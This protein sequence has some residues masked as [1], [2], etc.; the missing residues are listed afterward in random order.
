MS[1]AQT[2][3]VVAE[4]QSEFVA[5][6]VHDGGASIADLIAE[7]LGAS[8]LSLQ[9]FP[10]VKMPAGGS[11][12]WEVPGLAE[13]EG[14]SS[15]EGVI[16]M[17][18]D[19]RV[20]YAEAYSGGDEAPDCASDDA[21]HGHGDPGGWCEHCPNAKWGSS[22]KGKGQ[23]CSL[24]KQVILLRP[25]EHFPLRVDLPPSSLGELRKY[26]VALVSAGKTFTQV[27]TG[28]RLT[29]ATNAGGIDYSKASFRMVAELDPETAALATEY[30]KAIRAVVSLPDL[31]APAEDAGPQN[32]R[33]YTPPPATAEFM[34]PHPDGAGSAPL[35][36]APVDDDPFGSD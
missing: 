24:R 20:Y 31:D 19:H 9:D 26:M 10:Q 14:V 22:A 28:I 32:P 23:A 15:L 18:Q 25:H 8:G 11:T 4:G 36:A 12:I 29:K 33:A 35:A 1:K 5:L 27:E 2:G 17:A 7:N 30:S 34:D 3:M 6:A 16:V 21:R 13:S